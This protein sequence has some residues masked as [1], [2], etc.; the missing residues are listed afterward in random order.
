MKDAGAPSGP[1]VQRMLARSWANTA[2]TF[3]VIGRR[4]R[5]RPARYDRIFWLSWTL[6]CSL[7]AGLAAIFL[8]RASVCN[9][10]PAFKAVAE[11]STPLGLGE[12]YLWP[13]AGWLLVANQIDWSRLGR[14]QLMAVYNR[15][16][17]AL[18]VLVAVGLPGL[19][20]I[21]LKI[22]I[23]RARPALYD[24]YGAFSFH[25][26]TVK[27]IFASF[28]SGHATTI[29]SVTAI[30]VLFFPRGKYAFLLLGLW[31]ASTRIFVGA[32][33]PSDTI[34]GFGLG[35]GLAVLA[36]IVCARLGFLFRSNPIGL[37]RLRRTVWC[38][39]KAERTLGLQVAHNQPAVQ[40]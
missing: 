24:E 17:V 40:H 13:A 33:Y 31:F 35:F 10:P 23:G 7:L 32:H 6:G 22:L 28:P 12:W 29:G 27:A 1:L 38:T 20:T 5:Q 34:V 11:M 2:G 8:D 18:F 16:S 4:F 9:W 26:F 36:A 14:K 25:A 37:P 21:V 39:P 19:L 15:T 3:A 30:L